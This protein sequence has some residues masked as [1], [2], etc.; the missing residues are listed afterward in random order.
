MV[1]FRIVRYL[2]ALIPFVIAIAS[3]L[4]E[5][6]KRQFFSQY[7]LRWYTPPK[8][9]DRRQTIAVHNAGSAGIP[10]VIVEL[11]VDAPSPGAISDF[12]FSPIGAEPQTS[13][14]NTLAVSD[15]LGKLSQMEKDKINAVVD[16]HSGSRS[17]RN[18]E[19]VLDENLRSQFK[20]RA[21]SREADDLQQAGVDCDAWHKHWLQKCRPSKATNATCSEVNKLLET[22]EQSKRS[23]YS[24]ASEKWRESTGVSVVLPPSEVSSAVKTF[25]TLPLSAG[26]SGFLLVNYGPD[27]VRSISTNVSSS[28]L[29]K[30][31]RVDDL[32][33]LRASPLLIFLKKHPILTL[34]FAVAFT[35]SLLVVWHVIKPYKL[36]PIHRI[37]NLALQTRDHEF[38]EHANQRHRYYILHQF[39]YFRELFDKPNLNLDAEEV[40]DFVRT[41]LSSR[42]KFNKQLY[43]NEK[44][45]N[46][47]IR[48]QIRF[49]VLN[50]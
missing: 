13:F 40:L 18:L 46:R 8:P 48:S 39:R 5:P 23:L 19:M 17:L 9:V 30:A 32:N 15:G 31:F 49:L 33:D 34:I 4:S 10:K 26:E 14:L 6:L 35:L 27:P 1:R 7:D 11:D 37:F 22:W 41:A 2:S 24:G 28:T 42:Y 47:Y 38:W 45:L 20:A 36:R 16:E 12:Y 43:R 29:N 25:F 21:F 50:A 44:A 3:P